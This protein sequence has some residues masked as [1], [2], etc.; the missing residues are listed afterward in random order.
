MAVVS[1]RALGKTYGDNIVAVRG[2]DLEIDDGEFMVLL[3][4]SGCGK[5]TTLRMIA[6][7]ESIT[8]GELSIDG[9]RMNDIPAKNRDI[10]MVFQS[11]ALYPHMTVYDNMAF[12]LRRRGYA[13]IEIEQRVRE[14]ASSLALGGYQGRR[15]PPV[16]GGQ[17]QPVALGRALG[18]HPQVFLFDEPLSNLDAA[19]RVSTRNELIRLHQALRAT[20]IYVT[21]DQVEA[22]S[23][24]T[25]IAIMN[26]GEL[27]QQGPP[28]AVYRTPATTFVARFLGN[29][30][31]NLIEGELAIKNGVPAFCAGTFEAMLPFHGS[32][33]KEMV[34]RPV[35]FG[36]RPEEIHEEPF[37]SE[38]NRLG[39]C[40]GEIVAIEALGAETL[41]TMQLD[42]GTTVV[43]RVPRTAKSR[44]GERTSVWIDLAECRLFDPATG[45]MLS[46]DLTPTSLPI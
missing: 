41:L 30:P 28:L 9:A 14:A 1:L 32:E 15:P 8:S 2:V 19:L 6:G 13:R 33:L 11:Y 34:G 43:A 18:R 23:M 5:S 26:G 3:G 36:I 42:G 24:G 46:A 31:M 4:P 37:T 44:M 10:A 7:L 38:T 35:T 29:P 12:G 25:R 27:I 39:A 45:Q 22:M 20:M 40:N 21:H 16:Y 17:P